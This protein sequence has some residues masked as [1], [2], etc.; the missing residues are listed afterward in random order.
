MLVRICDGGFCLLNAF[1]C[2]SQTRIK[3]LVYCCNIG[4]EG[5]INQGDF[6][7][8][9]FIHGGDLPVNISRDAFRRCINI[10]ADL[11]RLVFGFL[12][13]SFSGLLQFLL[14]IAD[15]FLRFANG[16][17][18]FLPGIR[19]LDRIG[20]VFVVVIKVIAGHPLDPAGPRAFIAKTIHK[21]R[22][23]PEFCAHTEAHL[24]IAFPR[25]GHV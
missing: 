18:R 23:I 25:I 5:L 15:T 6:I 21:A 13:Q 4:V 7:R 2:L 22:P 11:L 14:R 8:D 19:I 10:L 16:A 9:G 3:S 1:V 17:L 24:L 12:T 20:Q